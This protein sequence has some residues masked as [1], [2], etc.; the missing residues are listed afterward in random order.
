[1][2]QLILNPVEQGIEIERFR[3]DLPSPEESGLPKSVS[4]ASTD[5][6]DFHI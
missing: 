2:L 5:G 3:E 6:N 1:V 4:S